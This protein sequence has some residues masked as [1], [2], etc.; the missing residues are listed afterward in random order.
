MAGGEGARLRPLTTRV[1]KPL[2]PVAGT[3]IIDHVM[4]LLS[5]HG[6]TETV[7]T[8]HYLSALLR[9]YLG[10][11]SEHNMALSYVSED[12]PMGTAGS[13]RNAA[14]MLRGEPFL[15]VSADAVTDLDLTS[16]IAEHR[17]S[18]SLV[19]VA[20]A[21]S[22]APVDFGVPVVREDG[23]VERFVEKPSWG[24]VLS[25]LVSTGIY[26]MEPEV[27]EHISTD[28]AQDWSSDVLPALVA[29]GARI[30]TWVTDAYWEDVGDLPAYVRAQLDVLER[31]V[32]LQIDGFEMSPGIFVGPGVQIHRDARIEAPAYLGAYS[33][34]EASAVVGPAAV[35]G[36]NV[37]VGS[38]VTVE[39]SIVHDNVYLGPGSA[40]RGC[41]VGRSTDVMRGARVEDGAVVAD[42]CTLEEESI[43]G[44]GV[45]VYPD[46]TVEAGA[47]VHESV[48]WESLVRRNMFGTRGI[49]GI[50]NVVVTPELA[51]QLANALATTLPKG[52]SVT[53]GRDHS[54]AA[55]ALSRTI[56]GAM[57]T[58]SMNVRDLEVTPDPIVRFDVAR[59]SLAGISVRT[60]PGDPQ[61]LDIQVLDSRGRELADSQRALLERTLARHEFR[62]AFPDEIGDMEFP[63]RVVDDY[64]RQLSEVVDTRGVD[65]LRV[66]VDCA[67]GVTSLLVP[68]VLAGV[69]VQAHLVN[70][71]LDATHSTE[72]GDQRRA[73]LARLGAL[74]SSSRSDFGV[75]FD[76]TG[77]RLSLVD[78]TGAA[79]DDGRALLVV[80]DLVAAERGR[81]VAAVDPATT[82]QAERVA[83]HHGVRVIRTPI[84]ASVGNRDDLIIA[85]DGRRGFV[86]PEMGEGMDAVAMFVRLVGLVGRTQ[87][88]MREIDARIPRTHMA[89]RVVDTPWARKGSVMR[90]ITE[91]AT[92]SGAP[93]QTGDGV[94][95]DLG[96]GEWVLV[97]AD[98]DRARTQIWTEGKDRARADLL[99][100]QWAAAAGRAATP[101]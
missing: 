82:R 73:A 54:R 3:P 58:A 2:L 11:G 45:K 86:V 85:A 88:R 38:G 46:K 27:L 53:I 96:R 71:R 77:Q 31:R 81:G 30:G 59:N 91:L 9:S 44:S 51:V 14:A 60:T 62:R 50:V 36:A 19:T 98:A 67:D 35:L 6:V 92:A 15:V 52:A 64:V 28:G 89:R 20:L 63:A 74:V 94:R 40:L 33:R 69:G 13:V 5:R 39:R 42:K 72:T 99:A 17:R 100:E 29:G 61:S 55:R 22:A 21:R 49:S 47:V 66:V 97:T 34:V 79:L 43:I 78:E 10:D 25:D 56:A 76:P 7:L 4:R 87:L 70:A 41:V 8:V 80:L 26:V 93:V 24:Q 90:A 32:D 75:R 84:S 23:S 101:G 18:G 68:R 12:C 83:A 48:M 16:L 57:T 1:P 37:A 95:V 65:D